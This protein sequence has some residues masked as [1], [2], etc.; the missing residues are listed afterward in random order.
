LL[1]HSG[2]VRR[3]IVAKWPSNSA[4]YLPILF[5]ISCRYTRLVHQADEEKHSLWSKER[6]GT[7]RVDPIVLGT[8]AAKFVAS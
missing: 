3:G 1:P 4:I 2:F 5:Y 7:D 6:E 8:D